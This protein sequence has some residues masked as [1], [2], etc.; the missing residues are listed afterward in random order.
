M[1]LIFIKLRYSKVTRIAEVR[2]NRENLK[3][4]I[5]LDWANWGSRYVVKYLVD[6]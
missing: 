6:N 3:I 2:L 5:V 4:V 1:H